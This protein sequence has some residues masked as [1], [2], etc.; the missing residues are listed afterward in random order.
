MLISGKDK[1]FEENKMGGG[2]LHYIREIT[3][4]F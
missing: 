3:E 4:G 2:A 1:C